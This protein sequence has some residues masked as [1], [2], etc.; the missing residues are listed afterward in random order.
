M[1]A[2]NSFIFLLCKCNKKDFFSYI[3]PVFNTLIHLSKLN[4]KTTLNIRGVREKK[5]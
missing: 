5:A 1:F 2:V 3:F 4:D